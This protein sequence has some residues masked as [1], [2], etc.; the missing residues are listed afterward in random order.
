[1]AEMGWR[2][3][4]QTV[5][6]DA[7]GAMRYT[8]IADAIRERELRRSFGATPQQTVVAIITTSI[9]KEAEHSPFE[10][11]GRGDYRLRRNAATSGG[12]DRSLTPMN[13]ASAPP[14]A[15]S[16]DVDDATEIAGGAVRAFGILW[17][18]DWID[19]SAQ[20][21]STDAS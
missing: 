21:A 16:S 18:R 5:L 4:I 15:S 14:S 8:D 13:R 10:R 9:K 19:W 12:D 17:R 3:A 1:M 7:D 11:V 20:A 2:E 6:A